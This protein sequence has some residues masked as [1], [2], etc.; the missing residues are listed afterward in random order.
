MIFCSNNR[1]DAGLLH[2]FKPARMKTLL[3][4]CGFTVTRQNDFLTVAA[5]L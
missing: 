5:K 4:D 3:E 1:N 2:V